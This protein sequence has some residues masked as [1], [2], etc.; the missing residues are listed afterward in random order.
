MKITLRI[1]PIAVIYTL[2]LCCWAR[3]SEPNDLA[4]GQPTV[5]AAVILCKGTIDDG[6]YRSI[7]R[8]TQ[9]ALNSG[10]KYLIYDIGTYG[11]FLNSA[12]DISKYFIFDISKKA[13]TIA[14]VTSEAISAGALI[15]VSCQDIIMRE[16]TT[17]GDCAPI[18][19]G[20]KLEGVERE[21]A[22][23]FVRAAFVRASEANG[24]PALLLKAMVSMQTEVCRVHNLATGKDEFFESDKLPSDANVYDLANKERVVRKDE[25]LTITSSKA[26]EY[27]IARAQVK[28]LAGAL[29]FL[30]RRD[31]VIFAGEPL[32]LETSWSEEMVRWLNSPAVMGVLFMLALLG[33][34]TEFSAPGFGLPGLAALVCFALIIGSKYFVGL[35]NWVEVLL[36]LV[37]LVLLAIE[38]LVLPGFGIA[39]VLGI[40]CILVGLF[41]M[42]I[43]NPPDSLHWP[44]TSFDWKVFTDGV[45][46]LTFGFVGFII[47]ALFLAKYLPRLQFLSGLVLTPT[48]AGASTPAI[49]MTAPEG[50]K[51]VKVGD[52]GEA[53]STLRPAGR[54]KFG[55]AVIDVVAEAEFIGKDTEVH[56]TEIHGNRVVVRAT[57]KTNGPR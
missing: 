31:G 57:K 32:V 3:G 16:N 29:E 39:G 20:D 10:V 54:A 5:R 40:A 48:A 35:A 7:R 8:R 1:I 51:G 21:K 6:L 56:I 36:F 18:T 50:T 22:E 4:G 43:K 47:L 38:I 49:S 13:H 52:I 19:V 9:I 14:Y 23:S 37:G 41:G 44:H 11:G 25:L 34:Y 12:D 42:L 24:Y 2:L 27:G 30:S 28:D 15:S 53:I 33:V 46:G 26:F 55:D 17:I 45:L